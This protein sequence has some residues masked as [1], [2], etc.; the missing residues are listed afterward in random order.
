MN[1]NFA[2]KSWCCSIEDVWL[3]RL[4]VDR[5]PQS[6]NDNSLSPWQAQV[7]NSKYENDKQCVAIDYTN[8]IAKWKA[9]Y[10]N[11][12]YYDRILNKV[13]FI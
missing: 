9:C 13:H 4:E 11:D 6:V 5:R 10:I 7:V 8:F 3:S 12:K 1:R 2:T